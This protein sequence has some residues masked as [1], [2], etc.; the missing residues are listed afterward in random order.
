MST[1]LFDC[2]SICGDWFYRGALG[3]DGRSE[4]VGGYV[5]KVWGV[6]LFLQK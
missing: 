4:S 3:K 1:C 5:D 6:L 2:S